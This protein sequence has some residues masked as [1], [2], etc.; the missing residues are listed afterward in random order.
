MA[1][2]G[3]NCDPGRAL[4]LGIVDELQPA[5]QI[6]ARSIARARE[7]AAA[8]RQSYG[9]I[10]RQLRATALA[11]IER[12]LGASDPLHGNWIGAETGAAAERVLRGR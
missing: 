12:A 2:G 1:L 4:S 10:K 8:P 6:W 9:R 5:D 3:K 7:L 11:E